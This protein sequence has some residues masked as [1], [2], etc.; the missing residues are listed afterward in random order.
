MSINIEMTSQEVADLKEITKLDDDAGAVAQA[1]R[2]YLRL[3]RLRELKAAAGNVEFHSNWRE[4]EDLE[5][6]ETSFPK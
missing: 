4:L 2:E 3:T 5:F 6:G 1:A